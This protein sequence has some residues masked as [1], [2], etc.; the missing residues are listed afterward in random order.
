MFHLLVCFLFV[1]HTLASLESSETRNPLASSTLMLS[2]YLKM[3]NK[4]LVNETD[5]TDGI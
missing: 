2:Q 1:T 3:T 5:M 4:S